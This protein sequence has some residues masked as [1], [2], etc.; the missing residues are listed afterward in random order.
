M[1]RTDTVGTLNTAVKM[2]EGVL[3][4]TFH[5]T[6]VVVASLTTIKLDTGGHSTQTTKVRMNQASRQFDL[7]YT[8][9]SKQFEWFVDTNGKTIKFDGNVIQFPR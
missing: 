3:T 1:S 8:V 4:V 5:Q 2:R 7:G 6:D 9:Y